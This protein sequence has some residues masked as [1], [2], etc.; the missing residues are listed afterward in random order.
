MH[1]AGYA[2]GV[3]HYMVL[4]LVFLDIDPT[5]SSV[6][7]G[8]TSDSDVQDENHSFCSGSIY[9]AT[10]M[11]AMMV[12]FIFGVICINLW[13]QYEQRMHHVILADIRRVAV[14]DEAKDKDEDNLR[15]SQHY[16]LP[17]YRRWFRYVLC[18][19]YLAEMLL[20]LSFAILLEIPASAAVQNNYVCKNMINN[21]FEDFFFFENM[22][23]SL[24]VGRRY[25][26]WM[27]FVWVAVNLTVS[28]MNSYD[29]Y[30]SRYNSSTRNSDNPASTDSASRQLLADNLN[31][32]KALFP[33]IL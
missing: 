13:L 7:V 3:G 10:K 26:H 14:D 30:N 8:S 28:A 20:Y 25:R 24:F 17:P 5:N 18:P 31:Q 11:T 4:P 9:S 19:H 1:I 12:I 29:W 15:Q 23:G 32:R 27:L 2:L 6:V 22:N 33:K 16:S 21:N